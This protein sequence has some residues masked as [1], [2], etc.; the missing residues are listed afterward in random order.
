MCD[1][2][3]LAVTKIDKLTLAMDRLASALEKL[4]SVADL[5]EGGLHGDAWRLVGAGRA[6]DAV[7]REL[8]LKG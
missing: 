5:G 4:P 3:E 2:K 6:D 1:T 8:A 7:A